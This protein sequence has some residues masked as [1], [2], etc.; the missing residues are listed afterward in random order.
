[1]PKILVQIQTLAMKVN[2]RSLLSNTLKVD[3]A[4][5]SVI[6]YLKCGMK[7][8]LYF[9]MAFF[10]TLAPAA[11][12]D[13]AK[14]IDEI[15]AYLEFVDYGGITIFAAQIPPSEYAKMMVIDVHEGA[16]FAK[17]HIPGTVNIELTE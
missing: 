15:S 16:Q 14:I 4:I 2:F 8:Q 11:A 3:W 7:Q 5:I 10:L 1:M 17:E 13:K 6:T 9:V 12:N